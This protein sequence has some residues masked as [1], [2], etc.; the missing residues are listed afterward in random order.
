MQELWFWRS[1]RRPYQVFTWVLMGLGL[2]LMLGFFGLY[3]TDV[4]PSL[5][6]NVISAGEW[7]PTDESLLNLDTHPTG[8]QRDLFLVKEIY[9]G[10]PLYLSPAWGHGLLALMALVLSVGLALITTLPRLWYIGSMTLVVFLLFMFKMDLLQVPIFD[11]RGALVLALALYLPLSYY[12]QAIRTESS[13]WLRMLAFGGASV[14]LALLIAALAAPSYPFYMLSQ[15]GIL[16]PL[17]LIGLFIVTVGHEPV[18]SLVYVSTQSGGRQAVFHFV[19]F[20]VIYLAYLFISYSHLVAGLEWDILYVDGFLLLGISSVLGLWGFYK[21]SD[22]MANLLPFAPLG[23]WAYLLLLLGTWGSILFFWVTA[24]DAMLMVIEEVIFMSHMGFGFIFFLYALSNFYTPMRLGKPVARVLYRPMRMPFYVFRFMGLIATVAVGFQSTP[25]TLP[26]ATSGYYNGIGDAYMLEQDPTLAQVYY[27]EAR[28][29]ANHNDHSNYALASLAIENEETEVAMR[30]LAMGVAQSPMPYTYVNFALLLNDMGKFFDGKFQLEDG[31]E[32]Y[33]GSAALANNLGLNYHDLEIW[34]SAAYYF[35][36][37]ERQRSGPG[38]ANAWNVGAT[39]SVPQPIDSVVALL[40]QGSVARDANLLAWLAQ[41]SLRQDQVPVPPPFPKDSVLSQNEFARL[42]NYAMVQLQAPDTTWMN[43]AWAYAQHPQNVA[44]WERMT[45]AKVYTDLQALDFARAFSGLARLSL[46]IPRNAGY[47]LTV[48]GVLAMQLGMPEKAIEALVAARRES[49]PLA[50][51]HLAFAFWEANQPQQMVDYWQRELVGVNP[52]HEHARLAQAM[53][54]ALE[55]M[56]GSEQVLT[57]QQVSWILRYRASE[58]GPDVLLGLW[59]NLDDAELKAISGI[60]LLKTTPAPVSE[61]VA[62]GLV[63]LAVPTITLA[64]QVAW[65][66]QAY[67]E[68]AYAESL[69]LATPVTLRQR[70]VKNFLEHTELPRRR[71]LAL[72]APFA[73]EPVMRVSEALIGQGDTLGAYEV[74]LVATNFNP[75]DTQLAVNYAT[76]AMMSGYFSLGYRTLSELE[77][78]LPRAE[79]LALRDR[80]GELEKQLTPAEFLNP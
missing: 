42:Y 71:Q 24:N 79:F 8:I 61:A 11:N 18:A 73:V 51:P 22:M 3:V 34:D 15:Y 72:S 68:G 55:W 62:R 46:R 63:E 53:L 27:L 7:L 70:L 78:V 56:P 16:L 50:R 76:Q 80:F 31:L 13:L 9:R 14:L 40:Y 44:W 33:P 58:L 23:A 54:Q 60:R 49:Y 52:N 20:L 48:Q 10:S 69:L 43:T 28:L 21:R 35:Q 37:S 32:R 36:R 6:W 12:F 67:R 30:H 17:C 4:I 77:A 47:Y 45:L 19:T 29:Y 25:D 65:E 74:A 41:Q 66:V 5:S 59:R 38:G 39:L 64:Q 57:E 1:W 75:W 26:R 2:L